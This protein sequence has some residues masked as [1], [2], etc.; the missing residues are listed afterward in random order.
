[1]SLPLPPPVPNGKGFSRMTRAE[2]QR[3]IEANQS[4]DVKFHVM[5]DYDHNGRKT[6][7]FNVHAVP[8]HRKLVKDAIAA[9]QP[10]PPEVLA[11]YPDL[12]PQAAPAAAGPAPTPVAPVAPA[13]PAGADYTPPGA[14]YTPETIPPEQ[15]LANSRR[16]VETDETPEARRASAASAWVYAHRLGRPE[17]AA[18]VEPL[19]EE[20]GVGR[21]G[22][23]GEVVPFNGRYH[24]TGRGV[25]DGQMVRVVRAGL[26]NRGVGNVRSGA[27]MQE[28]AHVE[29]AE[30]SQSRG[31]PWEPPAGPAPAK[32]ARKRRRP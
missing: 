8:T 19:L 18:A 11:D 22:T 2:A 10:V 25:A 4:D 13:A 31:T 21:F 12:A 23:P 27:W 14:D 3:H 29:P 15:F 7:G 28:R 17:L 5:Y 6:G 20:H 24:Q 30:D 9:G 26:H 1:M 16:R 32:P